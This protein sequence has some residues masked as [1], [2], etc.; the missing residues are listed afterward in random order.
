MDEYLNQLIGFITDASTRALDY[1]SEPWFVYQVAIALAL[2]GLARFLG[3]RLEPRLENRARAIKGH[4]GL[5]RLIAATLRRVDWI[6]FT[7]LL[8]A[9]IAILKSLT[10]PSRSWLLG[11]LLFKGG[12]TDGIGN[13]EQ[14]PAIW[15]CAISSTDSIIIFKGIRGTG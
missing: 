10:W 7:I 6:L 1:V 11:I 14:L 12:A 3:K 9:A 8:F 5:L 13:I 4:P 2:F 15:L